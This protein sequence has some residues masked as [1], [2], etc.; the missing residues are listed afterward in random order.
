MVFEYLCH[1]LVVRRLKLSFGALV[2]LIRHM[3][4]NEFFV[5]IHS[6]IFR[7][8]SKSCFSVGVYHNPRYGLCFETGMILEAASCIELRLEQNVS[9]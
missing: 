7:F 6:S 2:I 9:T 3:P 4:H 1:K 8:M 5:S